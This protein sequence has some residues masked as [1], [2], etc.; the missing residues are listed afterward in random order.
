MSPVSSGERGPSHGSLRVCV[1]TLVFSAVGVG[2]LSLPWAFAV[3]GMWW[4][5]AILILSGV[6]SLVSMKVLLDVGRATGMNSYQDCVKLYMG[7]ASCR[8]VEAV[9]FLDCFG[10]TAAFMNFMF[11]FIHDFI[12]IFTTSAWFDNK[13]L[14]I[15]ILTLLFIF[16]LCLPQSVTRWRFLTALCTLPIFYVILMLFVSTFLPLDRESS[17][18]PSPRVAPSVTFNGVAN[19]CSIFFFAFMC[20]MNVFP[21]NS[22][23][24]NPTVKRSNKMLISA[25]ICMLVAYGAVGA[26]G[27]HLWGGGLLTAKDGADVLSCWPSNSVLATIARVAMTPML[28]VCSVLCLNPA[29]ENILR[30][31]LAAFPSMDGSRRNR[32]EPLLNGTSNGHE[33]ASPAHSSETAA[34]RVSKIAYT[35]TTL[36]LCVICALCAIAVPSLVDLLGVLG[37]FCAVMLI[38]VFPA[39]VLCLHE[40]LTLRSGVITVAFLVF[41]VIGLYSAVAS[42]VQ[43][44]KRP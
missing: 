17:N 35:T 25:T 16:P 18:C 27:Y 33:E 24:A 43:F 30:L 34:S 20:H 12:G 38:F 14:I 42:L 7:S 8:V 3:L 4:G 6:A 13:A 15:M 41:T 1:F 32:S 28:I 21:V 5:M 44:F 39:C 22:E 36:L 26:F 37:G 2:I 19:S 29:R 40:G 9:L 31:M 10:A 11:D 23:L